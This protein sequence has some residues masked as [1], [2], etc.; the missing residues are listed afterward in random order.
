MRHTT[1]PLLQ[2]IIERFCAQV[3][4]RVILDFQNRR[5]Q[6]LMVRHRD[7]WTFTQSLLMSKWRL[8]ASP[9]D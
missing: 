6:L 3:R 1:L 7:T 9:S 4:Q 2:R 5:E 8:F